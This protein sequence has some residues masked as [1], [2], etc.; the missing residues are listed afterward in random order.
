MHPP[1]VREDLIP[2]LCHLRVARKAPMT[3]LVNEAIERFLAVE[4][5]ALGDTAKKESERRS[6]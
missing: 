5:K 2:G 4:E 6:N 3:H 1:K